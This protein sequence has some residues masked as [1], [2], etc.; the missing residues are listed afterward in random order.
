[1]GAFLEWLKYVVVIPLDKKDD[2]SNMANYRP[3]SLLPVFSKVFEKAMYCRLNQH[4]QANNILATEQYGFRKGLSTEHATFWLTDKKVH[5]GVIFCDLTK[6]FD[7]VLIAKLKHCG[8]QESTLNW[9][10]SYVS[11]GDKEQNKVLIKT[12]FI[13]LL[14]KWWSK[15]YHKS[16]C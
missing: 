9:F 2:V 10:K 12:K 11:K 1:M 14:G 8:I 5:I 16:L 7:C 6:A 3:I 4:L 13:T 15:E